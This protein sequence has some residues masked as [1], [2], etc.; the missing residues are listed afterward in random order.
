MHL[1][2]SPVDWYAVRAGGV[3]AYL[4]LSVVVSLGLALAGKK[5]L[6]RW[7]RF[8]VEDVHRFGGL[9]V[10][11]FVAIHITA[12]AL[13]SFLPFSVVQLTVP[14]TSAYRPLWV[15]LGIVAAE[16]LLALAVTNRYRKRLPH[17]LW[18]RAHYVNFA[19]WAAATA[20]GLGSGTDR[21]APWLVAIYA[22]ATGTV[23]GLIA[24]RALRAR[25]LV[26]PARPAGLALGAGA[27]ALIAALVLG[28]AHPW[29]AKAFTDRLAGRILVN[30]GATEGIVSMAGQGRG[31]QRVLVRADLLLKPDRIDSTS[32]QLEF[33]PSGLVCRGAV[34]Q[35]HSFSFRGSCRLPDGSSRIVS[36][37]WHASGDGQGLAGTLSAHV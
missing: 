29:N 16:L 5:Q 31:E 10:G 22:L 25:G 9:L 7:P 18:R 12:T 11:L 36:A 35:V 6:R 1:I 8:A 19:V 23:A 17:R 15:G 28:P 21:S 3:V 33:L 34:T 4:L 37:R 14:F 32:L 24:V 2:S 26:R 30:S 13:D 20:H 27:A